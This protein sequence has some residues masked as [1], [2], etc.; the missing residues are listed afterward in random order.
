MRC[1]QDDF[2]AVSGIIVNERLNLTDAQK[3]QRKKRSIPCMNQQTGHIQTCCKDPK[4]RPSAKPNHLPL[5]QGL[6]A[7]QGLLGSGS[8]NV[9]P[10]VPANPNC[11]A[12]TNIP[13]VDQCSGRK[14][15]CW[16]VGQ[17]DVDCVNNALCCFDGCANVC[18]GGG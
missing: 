10:A 12:I 14:S 4:P 18:Q 6:P 11:P 9:G 15:N 7:T 3:K 16:S 13:P 2:C 17:P 5:S 1:V 8:N